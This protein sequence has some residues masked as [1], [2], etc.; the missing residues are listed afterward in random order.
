[1]KLKISVL[2][3]SVL[4][5]ITRNGELTLEMAEGST[6]SDLLDHLFTRWP[7]LA[8]WD[9]SLLLAVNQSYTN[10]ATILKEGDEVAIM[11]PVQG[12]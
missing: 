8:A 9:S 7:Q 4:K 5:D 12:G 2:F 10:R 1:M 11:P 6:L 3:F